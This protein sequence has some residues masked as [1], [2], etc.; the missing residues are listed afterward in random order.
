MVIINLII[1]E[2]TMRK[3]KTKTKAIDELVKQGKDVETAKH[4]VNMWREEGVY[5]VVPG[6]RTSLV[7]SVKGIVR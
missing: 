3:V 4:M 5:I 2:E 7:F 1:K 6:G